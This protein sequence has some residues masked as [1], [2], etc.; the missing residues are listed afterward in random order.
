MAVDH[1]NS[2]SI[3]TGTDSDH[4]GRLR[5]IVAQV[6]QDPGQYTS[7]VRVQG[8]LENLNDREVNH[9]GG[10]TIERHI[11]GH[12]SYY[13]PDFD[14]DIKANGQLIYIE[15]TFT[16]L[17]DLDGTQ[18]VNYTVHYG[19]TNTPSFGHDQQVSVGLDLDPFNPAGGAWIQ[20][21][22]KWVH[23]IPYVRYQGNWL[24]A[25]PYVRTGGVWKP[26]Q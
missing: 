20:V 9:T 8:I 6:G 23:S 22:G 19:I 24:R 26:V 21:N 16:V 15:R 14:F 1:Q 5:I 25:K 3:S 12:D 10:Q 4:N 11:E 2:A 13:P 18:H 7:S 17:H